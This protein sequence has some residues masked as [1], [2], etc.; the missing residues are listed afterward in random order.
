[1]TGCMDVF[2]DE[3][4]AMPKPEKHNADQIYNIIESEIVSLQ[5]KHGE[6]LSENQMSERF[7]VSR[8]IIRSSLQRLAQKGFVEIIPHVG[9][10]VTAIDLESVSNFIYLRVAVESRVLRDFIKVS[11]QSQIEALRFR[12]NSFDEAVNSCHDRSALSA[13]ETDA[14]LKKDLTF[15]STYFQVMGKTIIWDFLTQPHPNYSRFIRLDMLG[16]RNLDDVL[17]EHERLMQAIDDRNAEIIDGIIS[18]HLNGGIRRLGPT[19]YS[20]EYKDYIRGSST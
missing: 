10:R 9:T 12:K 19:L 7:D 14:M 18:E 11:T 4:S 16:G 1:M 8:T 5:M 6:M 17:T 3:E 2:S 15:H 13:E 20:G